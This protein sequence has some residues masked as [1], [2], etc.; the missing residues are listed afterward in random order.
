MKHNTQLEGTALFLPDTQSAIVELEQSR[1]RTS[2]DGLTAVTFMPPFIP[3]SDRLHR[4]TER[5]LPTDGEGVINGLWIGPAGIRDGWVI[6]PVELLGNNSR[7]PLPREWLPDSCT[8]FPGTAP[9]EPLAALLLGRCP[10]GRDVEI[11]P[12]DF[13]AFTVRVC[14]TARFCLEFRTRDG[15][16]GTAS[17]RFSIGK[18]HW[19]KL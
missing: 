4:S 9:W 10:N 2:G 12:G 16:P 7:S 8:D 1:L 5:R 19:I 13:P 17:F 18:P 15:P 6:R 11:L 3:V 14:Y